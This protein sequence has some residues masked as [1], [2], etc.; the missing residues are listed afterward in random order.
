[1]SGGATP[2][3]R[4]SGRVD[5]DAGLLEVRGGTGAITAPE[6]LALLAAAAPRPEG[7]G[8]RRVKRVSRRRLER[9]EVDL[10]Q[11][12]RDVLVDLDRFRF[13][14]TAQLQTLHFTNH[15]TKSAG[16]RI[17]RRVLARLHELGLVQHLERRVGG[18]R[19]GS[20]SY[21]W[22]VGP[23]GDRL[24]RRAQ[25]DAVRRR[26]KEPSARHLE[27]CLAI[28]DCYV[29]T[30][31]AS[32]RG[33]FEL[34]GVASEPDCWRRFLGPGGI[35]D[36]LKP[37]LALVTASGDYED[38]WF[39]EADRATE[40]LPTV[41]RKCEQYLRYR[42][43]GALQA[44]LG[45]FPLPQHAAGRRRIRAAAAAAG[46][47]RR[48]GCDQSALLPA[49]QLR[50]RWADRTRGARRAVGRRASSGRD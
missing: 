39:I 29:R 3:S 34:V 22:R 19:A 50:S 31:L 36:L 15:A 1:M 24:L 47:L 18:I 8:G 42:R 32:R 27:H 23:V 37:D 13:L 40:S 49:A 16:A 43:T 12:E 35:P 17:C 45:L 20:A 14:T 9:I 25:G 28:G 46:W 44:E 5:D 26:F 10:S 11:R 30:V 7:S 48:H 2:S 4:R 21:V 41:A 6:R 38:H 33:E